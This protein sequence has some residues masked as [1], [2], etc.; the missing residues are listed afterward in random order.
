MRKARSIT[1]AN[2]PAHSAREIAKLELTDA[3]AV[4]RTA[5]DT[6][7]RAYPD[8]VRANLHIITNKRER[9]TLAA[10]RITDGPLRVRQIYFSMKRTLA[11]GYQLCPRSG[12]DRQRR[13]NQEGGNL[14]EHSASST[15]L[16]EPR[17]SAPHRD[18]PPEV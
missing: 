15:V 11:P 3:A 1:A 8:F 12:F 6:I 18:G 13:H 9:F 4:D 17:R 16:M 5:A 7:V 10:R 2:G 14:S